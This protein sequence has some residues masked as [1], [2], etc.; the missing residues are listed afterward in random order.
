MQ[1]TCVELGFFPSTVVNQN[2]DFCLVCDIFYL[3]F[4][5]DIIIFSKSFL[6]YL[7]QVLVWCQD[8]GLKLK[9]SK[10]HSA[11]KEVQYHGH[12][13]S[14]AG[15]QPIQNRCSFLPYSIPTNV[16]ELGLFLGLEN[17][18]CHFCQKQLSNR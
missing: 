8:A 1:A 18:Y 11:R 14:A 17:Y 2:N 12:I 10:S 16:K 6:D 5:I 13:V 3:C 4:N 7:D 9:T 15:T